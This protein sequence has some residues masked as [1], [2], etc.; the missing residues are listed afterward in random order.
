M[1]WWIHLSKLRVL[2]IRVSAINRAFEC[3]MPSI[4]ADATTEKNLRPS[5]IH[6]DKNSD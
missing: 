2:R 3:I 1:P 5:D 4:T 6:E